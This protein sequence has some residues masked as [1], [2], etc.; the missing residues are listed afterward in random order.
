MFNSMDFATRARTLDE[1]TTTSSDEVIFNKSKI[2]NLQ[3]ILF[4]SVQHENMKK[5]RCS[6]DG[7]IGLILRMVIFFPFIGVLKAKY[8][9]YKYILL[10][11]L[12]TINFFKLHNLINQDYYIQRIN[13]FC[14]ESNE[15]NKWFI[16]NIFGINLFDL[17]GLLGIILISTIETLLIF[18]AKGLDFRG[19][20]KIKYLFMDNSTFDLYFL[21][22]NS[23]TFKG[24][25]L[26]KTHNYVYNILTSARFIEEDA[27]YGINKGLKFS[28]KL[29]YFQHD[30]SNTKKFV[31]KSNYYLNGITI[32]LNTKVIRLIKV[33]SHY[34]ISVIFDSNALKNTAKYS[35][36]NLILLE[37]C[38]NFNN[39]KMLQNLDGLYFKN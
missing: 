30:I 29:R 35:D 21:E 5:Y 2:P 19:L 6:G 3:T 8:F 23:N 1:D 34:K 20:Y 13:K 31:L 11:M 24:F 33:N 32:E 39:K 25:E 9:L 4:M 28:G 15:N 37:N 36:R 12:S 7:V 16:G 18:F 38:I 17:I 14:I 26:F 22:K 10:G 27:I